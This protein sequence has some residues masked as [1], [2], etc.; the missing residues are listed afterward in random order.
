MISVHILLIIYLFLLRLWNYI[1]ENFFVKLL[2]VS[3]LHN[4][5][6]T[7]IYNLIENQNAYYWSA[8]NTLSKYCIEVSVFQMFTAQQQQQNNRQCVFFLAPL[9][10]SKNPVYF[11]YLF[12]L[13]LLINFPSFCSYVFF[14]C[15]RIVHQSRF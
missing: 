4:E 5:I 9:L 2:C 7:F 13:F 3:L 10:Q 8:S 14:S 6:C 11:S 12:F 15:H 1:E